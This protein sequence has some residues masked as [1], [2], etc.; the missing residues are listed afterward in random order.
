[1]SPI[2]STLT[3]VF[4]VIAFHRVLHLNQRPSPIS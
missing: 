3:T 4:T 2:A 1:M